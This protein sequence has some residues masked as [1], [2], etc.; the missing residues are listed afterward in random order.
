MLVGERVDLAE[1]LTARRLYYQMAGWDAKARPT[2]GKL[3]ELGLPWV[4]EA[5]GAA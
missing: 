1:F 3:V 5:I 2:R 4:A